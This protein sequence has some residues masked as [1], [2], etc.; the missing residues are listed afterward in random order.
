MT[1]SSE[2]IAEAIGRLQLWLGRNRPGLVRIEYVSPRSR[3][4]VIDHLRTLLPVEEV[5]L[6]PS[7]DAEQVVETMLAALKAA[8]HPSVVSFTG[9]ERALAAPQA[10]SLA[11]V[12]F[13]RETF[14]NAGVA[15]LWWLPSH[16]VGVF[17]RSA[18][19]LD[20][21]F[22][23][24]LRIAEIPAGPT[25]PVWEQPHSDPQ[26]AR[27]QAESLI[28][29]AENSI[30]AGDPWLPVWKELIGPALAALRAA[31]LHAEADQQALRLGQ[32]VEAL[33]GQIAQPATADAW[34]Q[35]ARVYQDQGNFQ[36]S[37]SAQERALALAASDLD[38]I[39]CRSNLA[40]V[41]GD[42]GEFAAARE[43]SELALAFALRELGPDH[44][45][46]AI[47]RSNLANIL[48]AL[49]EHAAAREQIEL[50]LASALRQFGPDHPTVAVSRSNLSSILRALGEPAAAREQIEL[51]LASELRQFGPD[52][53]TVAVSRSNLANILRALGEHAAA[54][55]QIEL[56]LAS[57]LRQFGPDHPN[58]A[59]CRGNLAAI[60]Y[61][62]QDFRAALREIDQALAVFRAK[63]PPAHPHIQNAERW[64]EDI[65]RALG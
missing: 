24:K 49:G 16:F 12:N 65:L 17:A 55:E 44:P 59:V 25:G 32:L 63:L 26:D 35:L 50:A 64:R 36:S 39:A 10:E 14:A 21:W 3:A 52:H 37:R 41:L 23:L 11:V 60:L 29:R 20:S 13:Q 7:P 51:A 5:A 8:P 53:P 48:R 45:E 9:L 62:L 2:S 47:H 46:V 57:G 38:E 19:D 43:Q 4:A 6:L 33:Q 1:D 54:R 22:D 30:R 56:A 40:N 28:R 31:E 61:H 42:M 27:R 15:Q 58:V 18:R 34:D